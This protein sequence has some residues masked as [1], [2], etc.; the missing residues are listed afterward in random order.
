MIYSLFINEEDLKKITAIDENVEV[1]ELRPF[2]VQAQDLKLQSILGS[3]FMQNLMIKI[4]EGTLN[5]DEKTLIKYYI[6]PI[7]ANYTVYL[8]IPNM[9][10]KLLNKAIMQ[11]NSE[12]GSPVGLDVVQYLRNNYKNTADFYTERLVEYLCEYDELFPAYK[13]QTELMMPSDKKSVGGFFIPNK[14]PIKRNYDK[15]E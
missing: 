4:D 9:T 1:D 7:L 13:N 5:D 14:Y 2:I 3:Q 8:A 10:F 15:W 11:L 6:Q 12:E